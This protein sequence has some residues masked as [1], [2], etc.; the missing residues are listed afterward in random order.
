[1]TSEVINGLERIYRKIGTG[2]ISA[3]GFTSRELFAREVETIFNRSWLK[4]GHVDEIPNIGDFKV[5]QLQ[6]ANT[7]AILV[8]GKDG[9]I[10]AFHNVCTHR[11][12]K[13]VPE[14]GAETFGR[15]RANTLTCRFHGWVF[16]TTG[17]CRS[18]PQAEKFPEALDKSCLGLKR[19][20]CDVWEGFVFINLDAEP[21][22]TLA[23]FLGG[24]AAHFKGYPFKESKFSRHYS[25]VL[26]CNWKVAVYA[27]SEAY[28]V[29]TIH[30]ATL[31]GIATVKTEQTDFKAFGAH[32]TSAYYVPGASSLKPTPVSGALAKVLH[33]NSDHA[34]RLNELPDTINPTKRPDFLFEFPVI[35]PN[36]IM[37]L[38]AGA[39]YPG[40]T[41]F[42]HVFTPIDENHTLWEGTNFYRAPVKPSE[43]VA[44]TH[45][46]ALHRNAW[47]ED[48]STMEDTHAAIGSGV[49]DRFYLMD[50]E[51]MIRNLQY[52]ID[53]MIAQ[54][55]VSA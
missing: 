32:S 51:A 30:A 45:T 9:S 48:T 14:H 50:E 25:A 28:H 24:I 4:V 35:F 2:P 21:R 5:K 12:N 39:A 19:I 23:D 11:G 40:M 27:F 8:R 13:V 42:D 16:D 43:L 53:R 10:R 26:K 54:A 36:F 20:H 18:V 31:P 38:C 6:F 46:D 52:Q 55:M 17:D 3:E 44:L 7:S 34:P 29:E 1:M 15:A 41:F 49:V 33:T 47:L 37:H 22:Q